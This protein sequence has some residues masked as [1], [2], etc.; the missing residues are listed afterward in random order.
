MCGFELEGWSLF[1]GHMTEHSEWERDAFTLRCS[2]CDH[3]TSEERAMRAHA[4]SHTLGEAAS[5]DYLQTHLL[6]GHT[7][8]DLPDGRDS[9]QSGELR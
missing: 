3:S 5:Q 2:V 8:K 6:A 1:L 9:P 7:P 4:S